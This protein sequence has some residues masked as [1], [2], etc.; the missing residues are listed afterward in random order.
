[1]SNH[2]TGLSLGPPLGDQRLDLC[3]LYAFQSPA[4]KNRTVIILNANPNAD[5][6]HPDAIYRLNIDN[7]GDY[8]TDIAFS[9]VFSKPQNGR[10]TI[11]VFAATGSE[12]RSAEAVGTKIIADAEVS[13]AAKPNIIKSGPYTF[14]AGSRSD[15]FFFDFDGIKNLFDNR[16]RPIE[17]IDQRLGRWQRSLDLPELCITE[18]GNVTNE[19]NEPVLQHSSTLL[20]A[21]Y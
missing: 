6:L 15:A 5:A 2:F 14:F 16:L 19:V 3:D 7:N 20:A 4:D 12:S 13:F 18:A 8:L 9:Y 11:S 21:T 1:M 17:K 10:Q